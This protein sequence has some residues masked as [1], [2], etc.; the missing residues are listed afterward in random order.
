M[1][2]MARTRLGWLG[3]AIVIAGVCIA[4]VGAWYMTS[5]RPAAGEVIDTIA[6]DADHAL[7][8]RAEHNGERNFIELRERGAVRWQAL[9][10]QYAGYPGNPGLAWS[11]TAVSI[12]VIRSGFA[13]LFAIAMHDATKL[14]GMRLAPEHGPIV[15]RPDSPITLTDHARSYELV[16]GTDWNQ[17]VAVDLTS[18][19]KALWSKELGAEP[20]RKAGLDAGMIWIEQAGTRRRFAVLTGIESR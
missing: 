5:A 1:R 4:G 13:E 16:S 14:G 12:R 19:G 7:V 3:P 11:Q 10:P 20:V 17:L 6:I 15:R 8:V 9:V 2:A 18:S